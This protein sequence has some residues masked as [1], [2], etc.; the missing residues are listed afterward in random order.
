MHIVASGNGRMTCRRNAI[1]KGSRK[2]S[3]VSGQNTSCSGLAA[4][5]CPEAK[6]GF[7]W[8]MPPEARARGAMIDLAEW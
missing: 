1:S 5:G 7:H 6:N 2:K 4:K 3:V 8:G